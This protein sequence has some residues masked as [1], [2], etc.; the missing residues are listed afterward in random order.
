MTNIDKIPIK[1]FQKT[2]KK[3]QEFTQEDL[4]DGPFPYVFYH[5]DG[6]NIIVEIYE[7]TED[8][9][10][11]LDMIEGVPNHYIRRKVEC[12]LN[13]NRVQCEMYFINE[14]IIDE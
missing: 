9:L 13:R 14:N 8:K 12:I 6:F 2:N 11:E 3:Y 5:S 4:K 7:I 1:N 10:Q